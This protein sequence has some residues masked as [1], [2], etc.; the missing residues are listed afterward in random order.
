MA[1][2]RI[3][4]GEWTP[5]QPGISGGVTDAKNCY[6]VLNGYGPIRSAADY[7]SNADQNLITAF[8]GKFAGTNAL[9][10]AGATQIY[11]FDSDDTTLDPLT[12]AGYSTVSSWD[13]AQFGSKIIVANG[14]DRLQAFDLSGGAY[15]YAIDDAQFTGSI[16]G[17]T[18]TVTAIAYGS[19]VIGQTISG[20]GVTG[21]TKITA[22]GTGVGGTGTY[23]VSSSQ[24]VSSTTIT[25][26]GNAPPAKFVTVVRDFVV[27]GNIAGGESTVYWSDINNELNWVPSFF[28]QSDSQ[29]L[30][31]GGNITGLAGGEYG[32]IFLERAIYRMTYSGSPFFFQ[33][34]AISR[35]LGCISAGSIA[36]FG[37]VT[38]FLADDGFY[39]CDGQNIQPIGLEKVNRW[40]FKTAI[41]T[42]IANSM[43]STI[44]P[45]RGLV[46]WCFP[47]KEG[48]RQLLIYNIQLKKWSYA[49]TDVTS[50]SYIL[51]PSSTL[52]QLDKY[53]IS[54]G[55]NTKSGTYT[56]S[57][58]L[59]TV[60]A[61]NH[62]MET[63]G[64]VY[65]DATSGGAADGYYEVTKTG[66]NTFTF[67]TTASGTISTSNCIISL[68][69]IDRSTVPFDS[70]VWAGGLLLL[71]GVRLQKIIVFNGDI[72]SATVSTA[73][74][75]AGP[76]MVTMARPYV[77]GSTGS[78]AIATRQALS[79]PPQYTSY[80]AANSD[81]RCPLRSNGR[82]HRVSVQTS[83]GDTS[84]DTIV[85]VDVEIQKAGMR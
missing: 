27:A 15:F 83:A 32:L 45:I 37:G 42:D 72:M 18:L 80:V 30:P 35:T 34:D 60:T 64:F 84:W 31:D 43:S 46:I 2:T 70:S 56:R 75:D 53:G 41:L 62:G 6:P 25:A 47:A 28:S 12:T 78:V 65:F 33:F 54:I 5:D 55:V 69:S 8:A 51:T 22:Y 59:V 76:S 67:R 57:G 4:F 79:A 44:D 81:G 29:Y 82:F 21:G 7:S 49:L 13:V 73:D 61:T 40:F 52:E 17:T 68:P 74:I 77:D 71:G 24:T 38:Y 23:T 10:A 85:G 20:A 63:N 39:I 16:S 48:N 58:T 19:L 50:I 11:K 66:T 14:L 1:T 36:Q 26:T 9:F 3:N